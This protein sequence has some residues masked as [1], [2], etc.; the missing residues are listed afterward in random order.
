MIP[1]P[2]GLDGV[3]V[4]PKNRGVDST[5]RRDYS[6]S[7]SNHPPAKPGAFEN[8]SRS[9]RLCGVA[10]AAPNLSGHHEVAYYFN[11]VICSKR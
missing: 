9:K 2:R 5:L 10:Y 4:S 7:K 1:I 3:G 11:K 6:P 8:V